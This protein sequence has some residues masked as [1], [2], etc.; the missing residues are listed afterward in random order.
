MI[1]FPRWR[2]SAGKWSDSWLIFRDNSCIRAESSYTGRRSGALNWLPSGTSLP[3]NL[4]L[5]DGKVPRP[6]DQLRWVVRTGFE[7]HLTRTTSTDRALGWKEALFWWDKLSNN[8][9]RQKTGGASCPVGIHK[10]SEERRFWSATFVVV[11]RSALSSS[12]VNE[13]YNWIW[14]DHLKSRLITNAWVAA[15]PRLPKFTEIAA[16]LPRCICSILVYIW[17]IWRIVTYHISLE[18]LSSNEQ[19]RHMKQCLLSQPTVSTNL[20]LSLKG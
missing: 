8:I 19:R 5:R 1:V 16:R 20:A 3:F 4:C 9:S 11:N 2:N 14:L 13:L 10:T 15:E 7:M 17:G 6:L 18:L 12:H